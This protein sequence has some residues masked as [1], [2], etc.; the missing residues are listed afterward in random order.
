MTPVWFG[1]AFWCVASSGPQWI[2]VGPFPTLKRCEDAQT[3]LA[4]T[5]EETARPDRY[6]C[7]SL[8]NR[9]TP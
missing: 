9:V 6:R 5:C 3:F 1:L 2:Q 8:P 7:W 4:S